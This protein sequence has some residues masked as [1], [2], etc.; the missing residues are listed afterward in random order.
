MTQQYCNT[1]RSLWLRALK[2]APIDEVKTVVEQA[3]TQY[4][5]TYQSIP[6]SGLGVLQTK[7]TAQHEPYFLGEFPIATSWV[8]LTDSQGNRFEG[9]AQLMDDDENLASLF[10]VC[11]A[12]LFNNLI[13][14]NKLADLVEMGEFKLK[15]EIRVR[16]AMLGSTAVDFSL[17]S[18]T[19]EE[20]KEVKHA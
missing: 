17:L 4:S 19:E 2:Q 9:A 16:K 11:D 10:A 5:T 1:P 12:I 3:L 8:C 6:Q 14:C 20:E 18:A 13:T 15:Q 7:D